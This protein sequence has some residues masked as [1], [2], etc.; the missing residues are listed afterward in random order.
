MMQPGD[1]DLLHTVCREA[2]SRNFHHHWTGDGLAWYLEKVFGRDLLKAELADPRIR[3]DVA[4]S[5]QEP[6][7]FMK[8]NLFSNLPGEPPEKGIELDKLYILPECK[9]LRIGGAL[10]DLAF[11]VG[12][13]QGKSTCWLAVLDANAPAIAFYEK[14]GFRFH[15]TTRV[16]YPLFREEL[17]GMWRMVAEIGRCRSEAGIKKVPPAL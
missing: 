10:V 1:I 11:R 3:Y 13:E 17:K 9:G 15:S 4:F 16:P 8:L 6:L 5:G 7:A 14:H 12:R 2:Y